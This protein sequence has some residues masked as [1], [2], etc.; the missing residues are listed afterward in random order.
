MI[1]GTM[2]VTFNVHCSRNDYSLSPVG[3]KVCF[4]E[5]T[6][7]LPRL[8][9][10]KSFEL[11]ILVYIIVAIPVLNLANLLDSCPVTV[12]SFFYCVF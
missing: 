2:D 9:L 6:L 1:S 4:I 10:Y 7:L 8:G 11:R 5:R 3:T 12:K